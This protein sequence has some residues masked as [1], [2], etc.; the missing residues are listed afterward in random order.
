M[1][2]VPSIV[3]KYFVLIL[4]FESELILSSDLIQI[5]LLNFHCLKGFI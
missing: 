1:S 5:T 3:L 4:F 2:S